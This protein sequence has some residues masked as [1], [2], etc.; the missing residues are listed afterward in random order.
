MY[1]FTAPHL[2]LLSP[3]FRLNSIGFIGWVNTQSFSH[4]GSTI[5]KWLLHNLEELVAC[6]SSFFDWC[7]L[8]LWVSENDES[9]ERECKQGVKVVCWLVS[10]LLETCGQTEIQLALLPDYFLSLAFCCYCSNRVKVLWFFRLFSNSP[11]SQW[12]SAK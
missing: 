4:N 3:L 1:N 2:K 6:Q 10:A 5:S 12:S 11:L 8:W 9:L 7:L